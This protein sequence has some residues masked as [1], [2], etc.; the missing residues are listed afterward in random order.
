MPSILFLAPPKI[1]AYFKTRVVSFLPCLISLQVLTLMMCHSF[2]WYFLGMY[3]IQIDLFFSYSNIS[4]LG[5]ENQNCLVI[6][7]GAVG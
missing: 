6:K 1:V 4:G 3:K 7:E 5:K 2:P